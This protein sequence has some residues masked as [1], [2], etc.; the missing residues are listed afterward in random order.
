MGDV[1][2][3][4][5]LHEIDRV[6][7]PGRL[8]QI[9]RIPPQVLHL[10][11][12]VPVCLEMT[13]VHGVKS[14]KSRK[15]PHVGFGDRVPHEKASRCEPFF[16]PVKGLPQARVRSV[17]RLLTPREP[18][19]IHAVVHLGEH[20]RHHRPHF[21]KLTLGQQVWCPLSME[22]TPLRR[23]IEGDLRV[24]VGHHTTGR[25]I[26]DRRN[27]DAPWVVGKASKIVFLQA[28]CAEH[29]VTPVGVEIKGP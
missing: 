26:D 5:D 11:E 25:N 18:A 15:E 20:S 6:T 17:I 24:I 7:K 28:F 4:F 29:R 22:R 14:S 1:V 19:P 27:C 23:K 2:V 16:E 8:K 9:S 12:L 13:V 3:L 10:S 21:L